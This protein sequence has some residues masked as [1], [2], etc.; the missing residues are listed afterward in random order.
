M[1]DKSTFISYLIIVFC[2]GVFIG[3]VLTKIYSKKTF[4]K[5]IVV[6]IQPMGYSHYPYPPYN[7]YFTTLPYEKHRIIIK[8]GNVVKVERLG[9]AY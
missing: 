4:E 1:K 3:Y 6:K 7:H 2:A 8:N 9:Y 5:E